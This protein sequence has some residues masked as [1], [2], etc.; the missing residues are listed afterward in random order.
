MFENSLS[1]N[2]ITST[3]QGSLQWMAPEAIKG[4]G[5]RR[6]SDIWSLGCLIVE[7]AVG[8]SPWEQDNCEKKFMEMML[9]IAEDN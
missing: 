9:M 6:K 1:A 7:M 8:G 2:D 3:F 4:L 5:R